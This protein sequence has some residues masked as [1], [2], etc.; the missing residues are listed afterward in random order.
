MMECRCNGVLNSCRIIGSPFALASALGATSIRGHQ[1]G[2]Y[3]ETEKSFKGASPA[4]E[5]TVAIAASPLSFETRGFWNC[6]FNHPIEE[7]EV[8]CQWAHY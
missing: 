8:C 3:D 7:E 5:R 1:S 2:S 4:V 6:E